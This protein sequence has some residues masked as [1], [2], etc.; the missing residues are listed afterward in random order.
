MGILVFD[1]FKARDFI[2]IKINKAK[3]NGTNKLLPRNIANK[4]I[5]II[6][7]KFLLSKVI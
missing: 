1:N 3:H 2:I 4:V 6:K 7:N 5:G